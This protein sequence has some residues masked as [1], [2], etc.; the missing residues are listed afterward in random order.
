MSEKF[1]DPITK[2]ELYK[3]NDGN[4]YSLHLN[5]RRTYKL[6]DGC[7]DFVKP[8]LTVKEVREIYDDA[9]SRRTTSQTTTNISQITLA[10]L[11]EQWEDNTIPWRKTMLD[12]LGELSGKEI[13]LLGNGASFKEFFF[14]H[15]GA[16]VIFTDLS[17]EV[18]RRAQYMF[19]RSELFEKYSSSIE[20]HAVD[21]MR[22][23]F[24]DGTFDIIYGSK[25]VGFL[26][27]HLL[28]FSEVSR[29]LK[30]NGICRFSDD[31]VAPL[32]DYAK[33][34]FVRPVRKLIY[35]SPTPHDILR[36]KGE[37]GFR[38]EDLSVF[39]EKC[40]FRKMLFV[41]ENFFLRISQLICGK[42]FDWNPIYL[43]RARPLFLVM[44]WIDDCL[45][46]TYWMKNN[47]IAL[48]WGFDK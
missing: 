8:S 29:C 6:Y 48:T 13:L 28:F 27:S 10:S 44:K 33:R 41:R 47:Y 17:L 39:M 21:A 26:D 36:S 23:P 15:L 7:F 22:L 42:L 43:N 37:G 16:R 45:Y 2:E 46:K 11:A 3:D 30:P 35:R 38:K 24:R 32:W 18:V 9:Y 31:A 14:L 4:L 19:R 34:K 20:F 40:G 1:I 5:N 12:A 25:F